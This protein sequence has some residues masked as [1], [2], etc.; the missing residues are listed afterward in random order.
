MPF[1]WFTSFLGF[2]NFLADNGR[3]EELANIFITLAGAVDAGVSYTDAKRLF[4]NLNAHQVETKKAAFQEYGLMFVV[5]RSDVLSL[6]PLGR[7]VYELAQAA[8]GGES[9]RRPMLL[10]LSHGLSRYQFNNPF[11]VGGTSAFA[12]ERAA[13][14]DVLPYLACYYLLHRLDGV[15]CASELRGSIFSLQRMSNLRRV[16]TAIRHAREIRRPFREV[17]GLPA[18]RGT[19]DNLKIYFMSHLGL[20]WEIMQETDAAQFYGGVDQAFELTQLGYEITES[21]LDNEW[22]DWRRTSTQVPASR[23][24]ADIITY[25]TE[26]VGRIC[27]VAVLNADENLGMCTTQ[28][29]AAGIVEELAIE[30]MKDLSKREYE[31]AR[32]KLIHHSRVEKIRN[33]LL[34]RDA[35]RAFAASHG[36]LFCEICGFDFRAMYGERGSDFIEGHHRVPIS[37]LQERVTLRIEDIAMVCSNCHRMLHCLPW[38]FTTELR[39]I[40]QN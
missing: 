36:H 1:C 9:N 28:R 13:S 38:L 10:A 33:P 2:P 25:F 34:V 37:T 24:F 40:L 27:P 7:Q 12:R 17:P 29:A 20:D 35:K 6:T 23:R 5:P 32:L 22:N 39:D 14:T 19:A 8:Q 3:G 21:I 11:P 15:L 26:G 31:E 30:V 16:E 18:N 4:P